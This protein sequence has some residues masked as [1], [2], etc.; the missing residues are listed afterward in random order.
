[1]N[2]VLESSTLPSKNISKKDCKK[3]LTAFRK[4]LFELQNLLY[5]DSRFALLIIFQGLDTSGKDGII[6][7]VM[8][9]MNPMG[10]QVKSFKQPT[11]EE[12]SHDFLWRVYPYF[13]AKGM[14]QVFNRS[15]Y[16]DIIVP[17]IEGMNTKKEIHHRCQ[18]LRINV[19]E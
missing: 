18:L 4:R 9:S 5:S 17:S 11:A 19:G 3:E 12:L 16:E 6:R 10:V 15:Y 8:T 2:N 7:H 1:M 13:P 14:I